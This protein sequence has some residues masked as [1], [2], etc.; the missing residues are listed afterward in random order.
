MKKILLSAIILLAGFTVWA[1]DLSVAVGSVSSEETG[2]EVEVPF[3]V[4]GFSGDY[5]VTAMEFYIDFDSTLADFVEVR[6]IYSGTQ[7]Y[8]WFFTQPPT[9]R[10]GCNWVQQQ[11]QAIEIPDSTKLFD[12]VF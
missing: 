6:N 9:N 4:S 12:I 11:L 5:A 10:F 7:S 2:V 3:Y 1:Q 8:E